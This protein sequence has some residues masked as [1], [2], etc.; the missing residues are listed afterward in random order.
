MKTALTLRSLQPADAI[1]MHAWR[2]EPA[3]NRYN[4]L[5]DISVETLADRLAKEGDDLAQQEHTNYR[6]MVECS[7]EAVGSVAVSGISWRM[8]Y[9]EIGYLLGEAGQG[10]GWGTAAVKLLIEKVFAESSLR[11]LTATISTENV[12]SWRLVERLGFQREGTLRQHYVVQG[13][14]VDEYCYGLLRDEF[15]LR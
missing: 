14:F 3:I 4:P 10:K 13:R 7:G 12:A 11:R 8:G 1:I 9:G 6:W 5:D 15:A 2:R